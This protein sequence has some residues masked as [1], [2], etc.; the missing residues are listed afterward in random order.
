MLLFAATAHAAF[1]GG[2]AWVP[3]GVGALSFS[4]A[5]G[6]S[7]TLSSEWDG[8]LRPPLTAEAGWAGQKMALLGNVAVVEQVSSQEAEETHEFHVG[9]VRLGADWRGYLWPREAGKV[10]AWGTGGVFG[11]APNGGETDT[12]WTQAEQEAADQD[13]ADRRAKIGGLGAQGGLGAEYLFGDREGKPAIALGARWVV[14]GFGAVD[15]Q[16]TESDFSLVLTTEAAL[17][18]EFTR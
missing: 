8:W 1:L 2:V 18:L 16:D 4:D 10:N 6:F 12:G 3:F 15:A 11:I 17:L 9:G 5:Q 7:G 14:G 13:S